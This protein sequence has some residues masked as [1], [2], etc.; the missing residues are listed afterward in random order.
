VINS[1]EKYITVGREDAAVV[2]GPQDR[3]NVVFMFVSVLCNVQRAFGLSV[4]FRWCTLEIRQLG[5]LLCL[6]ACHT[7]KS[8]GVASLVLSS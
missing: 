5:V 1:S 7:K 6:L 8:V 4:L 3:P 2:G